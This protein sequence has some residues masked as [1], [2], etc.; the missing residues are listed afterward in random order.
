VPHDQHRAA[1]PTSDLLSGRSHEHLFDDPM[2]VGPEHN[3]V[4]LPLVGNAKNLSIRLS[5]L[6]ALIDMRVLPRFWAHRGAQLR[7]RCIHP[8]ANVTDAAHPA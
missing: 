6:D 1:G 4:G 2:P 5:R 8:G 7:L 3:E